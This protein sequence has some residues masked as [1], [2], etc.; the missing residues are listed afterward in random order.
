MT[1]PLDEHRARRTQLLTAMSEHARA[2]GRAEPPVAVLQGAPKESAH[3]RFR[4]VND[5]MYLAHIET[6]HAYLVL[7]GRDGTSRLFLPYQ[8]P[9]RLRRE[10]PLLSAAD[11]DEAQRATGVDAVHGL[12]ELTTNL[13]RV[14]LLYTPL[15]AGEGAVQSWDT[16]QRAQQERASDPWDG[17]PD[18]MRRFVSLLKE[19]LP[20][21]EVRDLA[22]LLDAQRLIKSD[23]EIALLRRAGRLSA[24]GLVEAMRVT[25]P[26]AFEYE[27]DAAMRWVYLRHGALDVSYRA[28][29]GSGDNAW[30]GHYNANDARLADGDLVLVDC[31]PDYRYYASDITRM[32]PVNGAYDDVQRQL[33]GFMVRYHETLL[34]LLRPGVTAEWV[35][36]QAAAEMRQVVDE[37]RWLEPH[38][39]EAARR[40]L[41]F[42]HH[43]SHPVGMAVHDVGHYRGTALQPGLVLSVDPQLII[44]EERRYLRVED[45]V[46]ITDGGIDNLTVDA[47]LQLEEVEQIM[48]QEGLN[49]VSPRMWDD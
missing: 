1:I 42:P 5:V 9:E 12:D 45:T 8:P 32:W 16:L 25:R 41:V 44:P 18:R 4:Q 14:R 21:A 28:I 37:T 17:R 24:Q 35:Q 6:P 30:Y 11:P 47:P 10:G 36:E 29:V 34:R 15:R 2:S 46:A 19:R 31:G 38:Y 39:E 40:A 3:A 27:L 26:G 22:P 43:L 49:G 20:A 23:A 7:D 13:E 48:R 33:Y